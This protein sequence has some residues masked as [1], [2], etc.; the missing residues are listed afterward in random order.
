M[1]SLIAIVTLYF[2]CRFSFAIH[3]IIFFRMPKIALII[4]PWITDFK[5]YD[6]WMH[7]VGLYFLLSLLRHNGFE[8]HFFDCVQRPS[9]SPSKKFGVGAIEHREFQKPG[10]YRPIKR[11]YKLYG[12]PQAALENFLSSIPKPDIIFF[13]SGMTY[14]FLG[15]LETVRVVSEKFPDVPVSIGG[16]SAK[17]MAQIIK[18]YLPDAHI[19]EGS[20]FDDASLESSTIPYISELKTGGWDRSFLGGLQSIAFAHHGP[21]LSSLGCPLSC[22]YCASRSLQKEFIPRDPKLV[23]REIEYFQTRFNAMDFAFYDDALLFKPEQYFIPLADAI[24]SSGIKARFHTPNGMHAR[25]L[26][27]T[28]L[29]RMTKLGFCTLRFGYES[30]DDRFSGDTNGKISQRELQEKT[31]MLFEH[32]FSNSNVGVYVMAGLIEQTPQEVMDDISFIASLKVKAKPVFFSP[33]PHTRLFDHYTSRY[34]LLKTDPLS[35]NDSFF[36]SQLPGWDFDAMQSIV[37]F[38]KKLNSGVD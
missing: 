4:N 34:P 25:W 7:P 2:F 26:D 6:E 5:L 19:F 35:H 9:T 32:G 17:L 29:S 36:I 12:Q 13:G 15:L 27:D 33:V 30:G 10:L 38:A 14:W 8:T 1:F 18:A 23:A 3:S 11:K 37:D 20:L 21:A 16:V 22:T 31:Q 24:L 28:V